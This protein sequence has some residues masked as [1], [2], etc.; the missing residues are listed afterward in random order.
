MKL[1]FGKTKLGTI[2]ALSVLLTSTA[3]SAE[4]TRSEEKQPVQA[5][6]ALEQ[7]EL[8][9]AYEEAVGEARQEQR[10]AREAVERART[11]MLHAAEEQAR[12]AEIQASS[13][14]ERA[15][16]FER[17]RE[18]HEAE[19]AAMREELSRVH[20]S[21]RHASREV[22]R[23][24]RDLDRS[25]YRVAPL[26]SFVNLGDRAIIGVVLGD[27]TKNGVLVLGVSPDGPSERAGLL[28]GDVIVSMM[29]QALVD[30]EDD[31]ARA[32]LGQVMEHVEVGDG[33]EITVDRDGKRI[34]YVVVAD[35]REPFAWQS[36]LR[37]P[38]V[39]AIASAVAQA[40]PGTPM[41]PVIVE[42]I[43]I[44]EI[45]EVEL[46]AQVERIREGIDRARVVIETNR[47][48]HFGDAPSAWEY[49]FET[50]S[51]LGDGALR[52]ANVWFG[53]PVTRGLKLAEI[54]EG[55]GEYFKTDRGVLVLKAREDNDLQL[56]SGDVI[57][58][59]GGKAVDKP[60]DVMRALRDWEPGA[61]IEID[62]KRNRKNQTL[63]I[64]LPERSFGFNFVPSSDDVHLKIHT[65]KD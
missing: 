65:S 46:R 10:A 3:I 25:H 42:R 62:V 40:V 23:V 58:E 11:E 27:S 38:S 31:N 44:P 17:T 50:L 37:L 29:G 20:D 32:V 5:R 30:N 28:Q 7:A 61:A 35:K 47:F 53:L 9:A 13:R 64:V 12:Q 14:A 34:E 43:S 45:D 22:A 52:E 26:D 41:A 49:E 4:D 54:D 60:S 55:L 24:H 19:S 18:L 48:S 8:Q 16:E 15:E 51:E 21:L 2:L 33:L 57:L 56:Q 63:E 59:V 1:E 36:I 39:S 6:E